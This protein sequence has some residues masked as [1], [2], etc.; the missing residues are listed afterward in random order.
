M[1]K[2]GFLSTW[3]GIVDSVIYDPNLLYGEV[4]SYPGEIAPMKM[5]SNIMNIGYWDT[6]I[7]PT[8]MESFGFD[9]LF[10]SMNYIDLD[11]A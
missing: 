6:G 8:G 9:S 7:A 5:Q 11:S 10:S 3:S 2:V 4:Y 1:A